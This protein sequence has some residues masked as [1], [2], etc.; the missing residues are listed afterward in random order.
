MLKRIREKF[1][2]AG[3]IVAIVALVVA[4]AGTAYAATKL[5]GPQKKEVE[6]IAK[7]FAGKD[8]KEGPQGAQGPAGAA[9]AKGDKGNTGDK[10]PEGPPGKSVVLTDF[11]K[12]VAGCN[13]LGGAEVRTESQLAGEG[14]EVCNG[15]NG[16]DTGVNYTFSAG[17]T[18]VD[19]TVGKLALNNVSPASATKLSISEID[20]NANAI[21]AAILKW[22]TGVSAQGT[23]TIRE[24]GDPNAFV[25]YA[26]GG[27]IACV[28]PAQQSKPNQ[29]GMRDEGTYENI[30]IA[31]VAGSATFSEG[32]PVTITYT[33]SGAATLPPGAIET[34]SWSFSRSVEKFTVEVGG[35]PEEITVGG[36]KRILIALS[37]PVP[38][39]TPIKASE[40]SKIHWLEDENFTSFCEG[41]AAEP[42]PM[43]SGE[44]CIWKTEIFPPGVTSLKQ[45]MQASSYQ[46]E[47]GVGRAFGRTG[48]VLDFSAPTAS[49]DG[50]GVFAVK[51]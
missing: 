17:T 27:G 2:T 45:I 43:N 9:G 11:P 22:T 40:A 47:G 39:A 51:G 23:L 34:G 18:E 33:S 7:K 49:V 36:S 21:E 48:G 29:C 3:L 30:K 44:I 14:T 16:Q 13:E 28:T 35:T 41:S 15:R 20:G 42:I 25:E 37:L 50:A 8:G 26:V 32:D 1:G 10:G 5:T 31:F 38:R 19:P 4:V 12:G 24:S 6:K 46:A